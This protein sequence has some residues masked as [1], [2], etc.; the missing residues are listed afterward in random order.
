MPRLP[1]FLLL[2]G[3]ADR[4]RLDATLDRRARFSNHL[5]TFIAKLAS[6]RNP[7]DATIQDVSTGTTV[8]MGIQDQIDHMDVWE[9]SRQMGILWK[10][11]TT[12]GQPKSYW[13]VSSSAHLSRSNFMGITMANSGQ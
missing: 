7:M 11:P 1:R 4:G 8:G 5:Y 13:G 9:R 2:T 6:F 3:V 10:Q 12:N